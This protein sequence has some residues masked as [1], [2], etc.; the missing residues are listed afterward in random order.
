MRETIVLPVGERVGQA[1]FHHT[2]PVEGSYGEGRDGSF[3]G[4]YQSGTELKKIITK[5]SPDQMLPQ[6]YRDTRS[7]PTKIKGLSYE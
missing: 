4:K 3:S 1:V 5:W 6:A 7:L 2:G